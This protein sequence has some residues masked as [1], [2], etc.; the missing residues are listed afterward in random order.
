MYVCTIVHCKNIVRTYSVW[1]VLES[2]CC[3]GVVNSFEFDFGARNV[4]LLL[5][6]ELDQ[7]VM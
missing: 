6:K 4:L 1:Y 2:E 5:T 7:S 3:R